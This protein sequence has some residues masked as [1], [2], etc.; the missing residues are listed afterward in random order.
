MSVISDTMTKYDSHGCH[1]KGN[2]SV[3][4]V[5]EVNQVGEYLIFH[6]LQFKLIQDFNKLKY[7]FTM[8]SV[9]NKGIDQ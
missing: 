2:A 7:P 5:N 3:A 4:L 8:A 6:I 9:P 1:V